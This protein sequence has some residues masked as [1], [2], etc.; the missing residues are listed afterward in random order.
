MEKTGLSLTQIKSWFK[1][2]RQRLPSAQN[3]ATLELVTKF[4]PDQLA[5]LERCFE[6]SKYLDKTIRSELVERTGLS[7][8]QITKW[9]NNRRTLWRNNPNGYSPQLNS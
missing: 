9:F 8:K 5:V 4:A 2:T 7:T 1:N 3:H 6:R